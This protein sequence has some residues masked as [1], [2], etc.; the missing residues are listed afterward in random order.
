MNVAIYE[1]QLRSIK[2]HIDLNVLI[3]GSIPSNIKNHHIYSVLSNLLE[4]AIEATKK[5]AEPNKKHISL[6]IKSIK[7]STIINIENFVDE[8][9]VFKNEFPLT[10][11]KDKSSH[12]YGLK[13]VSNI[14]NNK[15]DGTISFKQIDDKFIV[16]IV[17]PII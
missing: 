10:S 1:A 6:N 17:L 8:K 2:E 16:N 13:S 12:G 5:L 15:Y 4:N 14:I 9:I 7:G 3:D 11:K